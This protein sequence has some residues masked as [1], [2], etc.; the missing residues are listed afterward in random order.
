MAFGSAILRDVAVAGGL[1]LS[2]DLFCQTM[3]EDNRNL[4]DLD[5]RRIAAVS[6]FSGLY[7]G[8]VCNLIYPLYPKLTQH[9]IRSVQRNATIGKQLVTTG[10]SGA[11]LVEQTAPVTTLMSMSPVSL[12]VQRL[13]PN[14]LQGAV[15]TLADNFIHVPLL[16]LPAY[17]ISTG[18]MQ[19]VPWSTTKQQME[20][21]F[22]P[23]MTSCWMFWI[24]FMGMNFALIPAAARVRAVAAANLLW[25]MTLDYMTHSKELVVAPE[26]NGGRVQCDTISGG[27]TL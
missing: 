21:Q 8:G 16:Y 24:P 25:T 15:G 9:V 13:T 6:L 5:H 22:V 12:L 17:F 23:T 19:G 27:A 3:C 11:A 4:H 7:V 20:Q 14:Q 26:T 2:A 1:G 10:G 18:W